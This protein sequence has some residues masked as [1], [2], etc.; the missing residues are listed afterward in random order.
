MPGYKTT[1]TLEFGVD[2]LELIDATTITV[3]VVDTP[4]EGPSVFI[5]E[6]GAGMT[7][8]EEAAQEA[9]DSL[10]GVSG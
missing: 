6:I 8:H 9:Y 10:T 3:V 1:A 2:D 5:S 7:E 4:P